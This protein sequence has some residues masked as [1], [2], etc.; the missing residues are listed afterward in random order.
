MENLKVCNYCLANGFENSH[1][2]Q[3]ILEITTVCKP[4]K[5]QFFR[6]RPATSIA[7]QVAE[8]MLTTGT[9]LVTLRELEV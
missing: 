2:E 1:T 3:L 8:D 5:R 4:Y 6:W 9:Y 7:L